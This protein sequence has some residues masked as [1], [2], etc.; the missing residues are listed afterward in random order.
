M[1]RNPKP[2]VVK[3]GSGYRLVPEI[4]G[5]IYL[6]IQGEPRERGIQHGYLL[7]EELGIIMRSLKYL[8]YW[9]TGMPWSYFVQAAEEMFVPYIDLEFL[10]E[11]K[12]I[13]EGARSKGADVSW[14]EI[15]AWNG[16]EEL[17]DYW[18]PN[19]KAGEYANSDRAMKDHCSAFLALVEKDNQKKI[20]MAHNSWNNFEVGQ[21]ANLIL[22]IQPEDGQ[23]HRVF[24]QSVP[25]YIDSFSD[26]F[27]TGAGIM[28]TE[29]TIGGFSLYDPNEAPEFFRVRKAMQYAESLN[30]FVDLMRK[31]NNGG[32]ANSWLLADIG[33]KEI[34]RFELGLRYFNV[35]RKS[36]G[37]FVGFNAPLDPRI[38]NLECSNTGY[39]DTRRHQ[40]ARQVM[41]PELVEEEFKEFNLSRTKGSIVKKAKDIIAN[42]RDVYLEQ[43]LRHEKGKPVKIIN[44]CS[45]TV[46][47]HYELDPREYMSQP[48]RPLPFQPRG[49]VDGKVMD[50]DLAKKMSFWAR[51]GSSCGMSFDA[52]KFLAAHRQWQHLDGFLFDRPG[53]PW[54]LFAAGQEKAK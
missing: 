26:F 14:Q 27:V 48:G 16:Y 3:C 50:S 42:H 17:T 51:W 33:S 43:K 36:D 7:A 39:A 23:G 10:E 34:M 54:K 45:R 28:G 8:T 15:L 46:C 12:G 37:Y 44:P 41:L 11:I 49:A 13:A 32:Y 18:W 9:D 31:Q 6:H 1:K 53:Q 21:F 47:G 25:G 19:E 2:S 22:D 38:R 35:E 30:A 5:W 40:G 52:K 20:V 4:G 24:M 29:T